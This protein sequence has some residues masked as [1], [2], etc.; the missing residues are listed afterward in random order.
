L[1][2][3]QA[4]RVVGTAMRFLVDGLVSARTIFVGTGPFPVELVLGQFRLEVIPRVARSMDHRALT[5]CLWSRQRRF[6][7]G[8]LDRFDFPSHHHVVLLRFLAKQ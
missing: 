5:Q 4:Q 2:Q 8:R 7:G 3:V 1:T 6:G